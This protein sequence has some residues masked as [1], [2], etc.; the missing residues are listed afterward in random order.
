VRKSI[1]LAVATAAIT[2]SSTQALAQEVF[3][4]L[5]SDRLSNV[6][7]AAGATQVEVTKPEAG[8]E[9]VTFNDGTGTVNLV[10]MECAADGC[11]VLQMSII[12]EKDARF[13]LSA[14]N[15]FNATYLNAQA[16]VMPSG[17]IG[18]IDLYVPAGGVTEN[19]LR[20][21]LAIY[22]ESPK[23]F[24]Q[25]IQS[26]VTASAD[27]PGTAT[28]VAAPKALALVAIA[29]LSAAKFDVMKYLSTKPGRKMP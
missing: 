15:S 3:S 18:L 1:L 24:E 22:L 16:A 8:V 10:L 6:L 29:P 21:N 7:K 5:T 23:L 14:L 11:G 17:N 2:L 13:T 9:V 27:K 25:H 19:N 20:A 26:Q 12:F 28:P 4:R